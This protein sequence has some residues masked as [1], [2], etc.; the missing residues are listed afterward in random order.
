MA[1]RRDRSLARGSDA[2]AAE[3]LERLFVSLVVYDPKS[4]PLTIVAVLHGAW[5]VEE[6][7][8]PE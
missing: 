1:S 4:R 7:L 3:V 5:D 6:L 2:S 8:K